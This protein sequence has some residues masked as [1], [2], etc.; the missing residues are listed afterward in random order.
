M[1][2]SPLSTNPPLIVRVAIASPIRHLFDY[3]LPT[4]DLSFTPQIGARVLVPFGKRNTIGI[5]IEIT[6][7]SDYASNQLKSITKI[8]DERALFPD[9][10]RE[11]FNWASQYY[12]YPL[13]LLYESALPGWLRKEKN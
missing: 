8:L 3:L 9:K 1:N 7:K 11:L 6:N 5:I 13:G 2:A 4:A 12:Q 10:L